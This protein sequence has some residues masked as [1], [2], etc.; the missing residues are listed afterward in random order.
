[1]YLLGNIYQHIYFY[2][3]KAKK[4]FYYYYINLFK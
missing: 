3:S 4:I 1:M 2:N